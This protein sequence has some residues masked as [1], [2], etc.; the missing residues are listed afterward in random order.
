MT[1]FL[2]KKNAK[3]VGFEKEKRLKGKHKDNIYIEM[4]LYKM[5]I[6]FQS[7]RARNGKNKSGKGRFCFSAI[8]QQSSFCKGSA[9]LIAYAK[10]KGGVFRS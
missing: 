8:I 5:Q 3:I 10:R 6:L 2:V 4:Q 1:D 7:R 9:R